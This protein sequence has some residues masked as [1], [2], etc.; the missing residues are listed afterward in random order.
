[1]ALAAPNR[2]AICMKDLPEYF[3][4]LIFVAALSIYFVYA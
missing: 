1:M 2:E 4:P 3:F